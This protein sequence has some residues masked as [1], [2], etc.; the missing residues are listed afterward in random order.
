MGFLEPQVVFCR[1]LAVET[2]HGTE[3][4]PADVVGLP[5]ELGATLDC[6]SEGWVSLCEALRP[7]CEAEPEGV[8]LL[9]GF[10][11]RFSAPGYLDCSPW[12]VFETEEEA[13]DYLAEEEC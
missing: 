12:T 3:F 6:E 7:Y 2:R 8:R 9:E 1:W 10:G 4:I 5:I 11:A 13:L